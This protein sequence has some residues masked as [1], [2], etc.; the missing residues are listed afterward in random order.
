MRF[1]AETRLIV[2]GLTVLLAMG[3]LRTESV[4]AAEGDG[5]SMW[6]FIGTYTQGG[7]EGIYAAKFDPSTGRLGKAHLAGKMEHPSFLAI[8]PSGKFLYAVG[9]ITDYEGQPSGFV[10]AFEIDSNDASLTP[11]NRM[12]TAGGAPC[13][14]VV[15]AAGHTVLVANY[16]GGNVATFTIEPDGRLGKRVSVQQHAGSSVNAQRQ[17]EPHAHSIN[18]DAANRFAYAADLGVDKI[19]IYRFN[20]ATGE[21][22]TDGAPRNAQVAPG[23][24]P[25]HFAFHPTRPFAYVI[26][27][28]RSTIDVFEHDAESGVL[29]PRQTISTLPE[30]YAEDSFTAEVVVHPSGKFVYGSNRGHDS[31]AVFRVE[32]SGQLTPVEIEKTRGK[33]PR[34][35]AIDPS[36]KYLFAENQG[37]DSI[38]LFRIDPQ[39]GELEATG[40]TLE[41]PVPV[42]VKFL[43]VTSP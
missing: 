14:L 24:G 37:S 2:G 22:S 11:L 36:G 18:L 43:A 8:H 15:D 40:E 35:F 12:A 20:A 41:V 31:I 39:S 13:H 10:Q 6:V 42:C 33:T 16:V 30:G 17:K 32:D 5:S 1:W 25:R 27:E 3:G 21:L 34:N 26:N 28:L 4:A 29:T 38:V 7:S 23:S 19:Y 9:E